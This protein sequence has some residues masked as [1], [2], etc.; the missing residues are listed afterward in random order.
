MGAEGEFATLYKELVDDKIKCSEHVRMPHYTFNIFL[1]KTENYLKKHY[2]H[3][4]LVITS[5][6][7]LS[8]S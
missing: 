4:R 2:T 6:E 8:V 1:N 3:W 7:P 5:S